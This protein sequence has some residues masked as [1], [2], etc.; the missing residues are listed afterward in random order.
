MDYRRMRTHYTKTTEGKLFVAFL[1]LI[2]R[3]VFM[4]AIKDNEA[5]ERLSMKKVIRELEK[6]QRLQLKDG[7]THMLPLTST[8]KTILNALTIDATVFN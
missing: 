7:N 4:Q 6:I 2:I 5:T 1:G 8:Q 3:T